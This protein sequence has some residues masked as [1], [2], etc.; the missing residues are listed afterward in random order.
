M[1]LSSI[2]FAIR[3]ENTRVFLRVLESNT[4]VSTISGSGR[5]RP[6]V[7][8]V[9]S[10]RTIDSEILESRPEYLAPREKGEMPPHLTCLLVREDCVSAPSVKFEVSRVSTRVSRP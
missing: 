10:G 3:V 4:R 2:G 7:G 9:G 8:K 5:V 6:Q 1:H